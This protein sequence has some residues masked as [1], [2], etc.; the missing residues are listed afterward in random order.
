MQLILIE[1]FIIY[2]N[3]FISKTNKII[4]KL[5]EDKHKL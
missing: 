4:T 3:I 1:I 5:S 2:Y